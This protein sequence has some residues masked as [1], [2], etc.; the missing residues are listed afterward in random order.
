MVRKFI[1]LILG[2]VMWNRE[3]QWYFHKIEKTIAN[4]QNI[5]EDIHVMG[6]VRAATFHGRPSRQTTSG[7]EA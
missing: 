7:P 6:Y 2:K 4:E 3:E 5:V 1:G